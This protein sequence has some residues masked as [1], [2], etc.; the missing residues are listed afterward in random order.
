VEPLA[1]DDFKGADKG[2]PGWFEIPTIIAGL[3]W[4]GMVLDH[5][6]LNTRLAT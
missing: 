3:K 6:P 2:I 4:D 5:L 1:I